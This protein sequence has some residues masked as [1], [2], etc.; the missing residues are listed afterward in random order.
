MKI[1]YLWPNTPPP[2]HS[3]QDK[4]K[5][6]VGV[7]DYE[8]DNPRSRSHLLLNFISRLIAEKKNSPCFTLTDICGGDAVVA[9]KIKEFYPYAEIIV[10]DCFKGKFDTHKR[11]RE[12]GV[13]IYGGYLQHIVGENLR[14]EKTDIVMMLNT[15]RGWHSA[16]L[17]NNEQNIPMQTLEWFERNARFIV[18]TA[19]VGQIEFLKQRGLQTEILGAGEDESYMI[20]ISKKNF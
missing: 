16:Q 13:K 12:L 7:T 15:F 14:S 10:Q 9:S 2:P 17:R 8:V 1:F 20:C 4:I 18:V 5:Q 11:A 6:R 3:H 19:T